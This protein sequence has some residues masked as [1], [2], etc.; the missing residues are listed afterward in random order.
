MTSETLPLCPDT[1]VE[2]DEARLTEPV[3]VGPF[4]QGVVFVKVGELDGAAVKADLGISPSGYED[5][6]AHW[7]SFETACFEDAGMHAVRISN[8]GNWLRL[9]G[10]GEETVLAWFVGED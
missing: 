2:P 4:G 5:W 3:E 8:F 1:R 10:D 7:T 9:R 6:D